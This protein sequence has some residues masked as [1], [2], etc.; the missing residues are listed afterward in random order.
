MSD[1]IFVILILI[2]TLSLGAVV[3]FRSP[4]VKTNRLFAVMTFWIAI[5]ITSNFLENEPVGSRLTALLLRLDFASA[6]LVFYFLY[7]FFLNFPQPKKLSRINS[8]LI[9]TPTLIFIVLS[10]TDLVIHKISFYEN[11]H[12]EAGVLYPLYSLY[13]IGYILAGCKTLLMK[14]RRAVGAPKI[15]ILYVIIGFSISGLIAAI[16]NLFLQQSVSVEMGR[17][18][19]AAPFLFFLA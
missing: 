14:Y 13:I 5:W 1:I 6:G 4:R 16:I 2:S 12:F 19:V 10:F 9:F 7:L 15:Q 8:L 3:Y 17:A 11:I 18:G